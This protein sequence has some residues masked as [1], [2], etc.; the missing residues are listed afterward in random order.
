V[1]ILS[2]RHLHWV[3]REFLDDCHH[4]RTH[5]A[6]NRDCPVPRPVEEADQGE[7]IELSLVGG[8]HH[9]YTRQAA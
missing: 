3:I 1:I 2:E 5:R 6:L 8:W 9:R 4:H 7:I